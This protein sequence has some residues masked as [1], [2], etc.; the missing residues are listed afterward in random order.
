M[1]FKT[2]YRIVE[3]KING[4]IDDLYIERKRWY[5]F[6]YRKIML[7]VQ[8]ASI[9][10]CLGNLGLFKEY[11]SKYRYGSK[12]Y[13]DDGI[14]ICKRFINNVYLTNHKKDVSDKVLV[15]YEKN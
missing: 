2:K 1:N 7:N 14:E 9:E 5:N 11:K 3:R 4:A 6:N 15:E 8:G 10:L 13:F 12:E